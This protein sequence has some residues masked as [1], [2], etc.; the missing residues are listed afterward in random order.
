M[1]DTAEAIEKQSTIDSIS[2]YNRA[3]E[4]LYFN[5]RNDGVFKQPAPWQN[6]KAAILKERGR[7]LSA[8]EE[9]LLQENI[10]DIQNMMENC[11]DGKGF[12]EISA[13]LSASRELER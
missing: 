7:P 13:K 10:K 5:E 8:G 4:L 9:R 12:K 2:V 6:A 3:G 11:G 1:P